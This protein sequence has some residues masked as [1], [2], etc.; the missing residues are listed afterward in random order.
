M[1]CPYC[2]SY[3]TPDGNAYCIDCGTKLIDSYDEAMTT[4]GCDDDDDKYVS[5]SDYINGLGYDEPTSSSDW[6]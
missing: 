6:I 3:S 5:Y 1:Y 4:P 2:G